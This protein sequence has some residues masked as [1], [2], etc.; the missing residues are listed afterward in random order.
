[1]APTIHVIVPKS[2]DN[3]NRDENAIRGENIL[4]LRSGQ[5]VSPLRK[6]MHKISVGA[7][8]AVAPIIAG[9]LELKTIKAT[10][11]VAPTDDVAGFDRATVSNNKTQ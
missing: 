8:L 11:R 9:A 6:R 1:I 3:I 4:R 2:G 7:T 5:V 10:A